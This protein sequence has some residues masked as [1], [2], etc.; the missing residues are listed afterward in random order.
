MQVCETPNDEAFEIG[1]LR[2][3]FKAL[4]MTKGNNHEA[5]EGKEFAP[6]DGATVCHTIVT[7]QLSRFSL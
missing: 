4:G 7:W 1:H 2:A 3:L 5:H 6:R